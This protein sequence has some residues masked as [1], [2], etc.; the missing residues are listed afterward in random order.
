VRFLVAVITCEARRAYAEAQRASWVKDCRYDLRFFLARQDRAPLDDEVFVD[1]GDG[2]E[3]LPAKVREMSRWADRQG[4]E[5]LLKIDD[6]VILY[7]TRL[8]FPQGHYT[9]WRQEPHSANWCS[10][11]AYWLS[12]DAM[13]VMSQAELP[14]T[15]VAVPAPEDRWTGANLLA[16]GIRAE[17]APP[18]AIQWVGQ[19]R[20]NTPWHRTLPQNVEALLAGCYAA[21]EFL[22]EEFP[23]Y[24]RV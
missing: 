8:V 18:R 1:A 17:Q 5:I 6:D 10:G 9:G 7:P 2:Y 16:A 11:L 23:K 14:E 20:P 22:P 21:G 15:S 13:R 12:R 3:A 19:R 24:Y 4:Y